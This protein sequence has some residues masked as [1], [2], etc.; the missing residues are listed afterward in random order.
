MKLYICYGTFKS[1]RPGG[2]PCR[3]AYEALREAGH[4]P[5]LIKSYGLGPLPDALNTPRRKE[6]KRL[7]GNSWVPTLVLDDGTAIYDSRVILEALDE[8]AGGGR[9]LPRGPERIPALVLHAL[10]DG[11][12]EAALLQVYEARW[13]EEGRREPRW[14]AH[15]AGKVERGLDALEAAPP[16]F[17]AIPQAGPIALACALGYLDFRLGGGWRANRPRLVA[18]LDAFDAAV[19]AFAATRP[20]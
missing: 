6:V 20:A 1:P 3:N 9:L 7:T 8:I 4:E 17:G 14:L 16:A 5:E 12:T 11:I 13:R 10:A 15:Q 19:P 18:W 2:H